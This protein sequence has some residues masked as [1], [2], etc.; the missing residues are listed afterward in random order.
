MHGFSANTHGSVTIRHTP[1][2]DF[3]DQAR[4]EGAGFHGKHTILTIRLMA[5][6][7]YRLALAHKTDCLPARP[8]SSPHPIAICPKKK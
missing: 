2:A 3:Y 6:P 1:G 5:P 7:L 4:A 8:L